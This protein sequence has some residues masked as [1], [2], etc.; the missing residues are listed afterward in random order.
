MDKSTMI[1][2][3]LC[4]INWLSVLLVVPLGHWIYFTLSVIVFVFVWGVYVLVSVR[5]RK[6]SVRAGVMRCHNPNAVR[7]RF[8][9]SGYER[10][11]V[12]WKRGD[13][14]IIPEKYQHLYDKIYRALAH[15]AYGNTEQ[16][17]RSL[18]RPNWEN[19]WQTLKE[20]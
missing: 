20:L 2:I 10:F 19:L 8:A 11:E 4:I 15:L 9:T 1:S 17:Q 5:E 16:L 13:N 6:M 3:I 14:L 12:E 18:E 7:L